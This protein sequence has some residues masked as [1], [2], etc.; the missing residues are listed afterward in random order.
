[1]K[2]KFLVE[3]DLKTLCHGR[4]ENGDA[5]VLT[6]AEARRRLK[7]HIEEAVE[8]WGGQGQPSDLLWPAN[9]RRLVVRAKLK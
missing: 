1:M 5:E 9:F 7:E 6:T 3:V 8:I 4:D 2:F